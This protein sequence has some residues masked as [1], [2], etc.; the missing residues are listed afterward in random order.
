MQAARHESAE[1]TD[2]GRH[3]SNNEDDCLRA[4]EVGVFCVADGMGGSAGGD[5]ASEAITTNLKEA[6]SRM[7]PGT[8]DTLGGRVEVVRK[9]VNSASRW[10]K[11]FSD[12]KILG[13]MGS[14]VVTLV[15]DPRRPDRAVCLHAGDSRLYRFRQSR[16]EPLTSDHTTGEALAAKS[17]KDLSEIPAKF[18]NELTRAVGIRDSVELEESEIEVS[19][20]DLFLLCSDGLTRMVDD[21]GI[22]RILRAAETSTL[23]ALA[24][25][26]VAEANLAGGKDNITVVLVRI[27][28]RRDSGPEVGT[29]GQASTDEGLTSPGVATQGGADV[30][31]QRS[32]ASVVDRPPRR[33]FGGRR[34]PPLGRNRWGVVTALRRS[35]GACLAAAGMGLVLLAGLFVFGNSWLH[36]KAAT[37]SSPAVETDSVPDFAESLEAA[38]L[39]HRTGDISNALRHAE[40]AVRARPDEPEARSLRS[41]IREA[42]DLGYAKAF[43][44]QGNYR[45]VLELCGSYPDTKAFA[46]LA[47]RASEEF[48]EVEAA[49]A[50][51]IVGDYS[52]I[53]VLENRPYAD[54]ASVRELVASARVELGIFNRVMEA[55]RRGDGKEVRQILR[56][57]VSLGLAEKP[58]F[59]DADQ[60]A[61]SHDPVERQVGAP[62]ASR[63][64]VVQFERMLVWFGCVEPTSPLLRT[65]E[66]RQEVMLR[67]PLNGQRRDQCINDLIRFES[68]YGVESSE[69][70]FYAKSDLVNQLRRAIDQH[71]TGR[72]P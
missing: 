11:D 16:L 23:D 34:A 72:N 20:G 44:Q 27:L 59:R 21:H 67:S 54:K 17:G 28:G 45:S 5:L 61:A 18:R 58:P 65:P 49:R 55:R 63:D 22:L 52:F 12:E 68:E 13:Q 69:R 56:A 38:R 25:R 39:A 41:R 4:L 70:R 30:E 8:T 46:D 71:P 53:P 66:A 42:M 31:G 50:R 32:A 57:N 6:L 33:P 48:D 62:A 2:L 29:D 15:L 14:T 24:R 3:R 43:F 37:A 51:F 10:I 35:P 64:T 47:V 7:D 40:A 19:A 60:W 36:R 1:L 26:L 9:A